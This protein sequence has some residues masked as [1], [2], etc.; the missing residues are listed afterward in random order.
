M[1]AWSGP[2]S[3]AGS[4]P[5]RPHGGRAGRPTRRTDDATYL[6]HPYAQPVAGRDAILRLWDEEREPG[7]E[8]TMAWEVVAVD[9][10]TGVAR[11]EVRYLAPEQAGFRDLWIVRLAPDGRCR[12]F[13][14][15]P[16]APGR[17]VG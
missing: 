11:I 14:E 9:G 7:E 10:D 1:A 2:T 12:H 17:S 16:F 5:T 15:W 13:E 8:F 3:T 6:V 4:A